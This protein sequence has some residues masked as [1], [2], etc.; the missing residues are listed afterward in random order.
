MRGRG[1]LP[2][3]ETYHIRFIR[4]SYHAEDHTIMPQG[5]VFRLMRVENSSDRGEDGFL[6][7]K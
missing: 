7:G 2:G 4:M 5:A 1:S 3:D 6:R